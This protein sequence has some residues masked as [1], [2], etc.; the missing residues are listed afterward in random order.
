MGKPLTVDRSVNVLWW[1]RVFAALP[2]GYSIVEFD[3]GAIGRGLPLRLLVHG[4]SVDVYDW[5]LRAIAKRHT[6]P[7]AAAAALARLIRTQ[8][9]TPPGNTGVEFEP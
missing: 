7:A 4:V 3:V 1:H 9:R 2:R 6:R 5:R 8:R